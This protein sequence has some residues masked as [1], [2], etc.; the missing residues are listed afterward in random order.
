MQVIIK[1]FVSRAEK[2]CMLTFSHCNETAITEK[3]FNKWKSA[4]DKFK[5]HHN[6]SFHR[7]CHYKLSV[8]DNP[9]VAPIEILLQ[10]QKDEEQLATR[11]G[12][13]EKLKILKILT[14]QGI[15][16][17]KANEMDGNL[18]QFLQYADTHCPELKKL[19]QDGK[20]MSHEIDNELMKAMYRNCLMDL[21]DKIK[22]SDFFAIVAD[23]TKDI[24]GIEQLSF[25]MRWVD[26][27]FTIH[28][29]FIGVHQASKCD[30]ETIVKIIKISFSVWQSISINAEIKLTMGPPFCKVH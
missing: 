21:L 22:S 14:G 4:L 16:L 8:R 28:E 29:D 11:R 25:C 2:L 10:K 17:R 6:S 30:A 9:Y 3:G 27:D 18:K 24:S 7:E 15:P 26:E 1:H 23:E 12:L 20:Y 19:L 13:L 5:Q